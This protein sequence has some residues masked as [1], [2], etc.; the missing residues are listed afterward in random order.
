MF[1]LHEAEPAL[2]QQTKVLHAERGHQDLRGEQH[3]AD[4]IG[5]QPTHNSR[6]GTGRNATNPPPTTVF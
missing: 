3:E 4:D 2:D 1:E 6:P 5:A